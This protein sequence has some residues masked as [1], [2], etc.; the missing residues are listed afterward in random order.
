[1]ATSIRRFPFGKIDEFG[2]SKYK[3]LDE[4]KYVII[5]DLPSDHADKIE[6]EKNKYHVKLIQSIALECFLA[7]KEIFPDLMQN[8][9]ERG[10]ELL[11]KPWDSPGPGA[12]ENTRN[13]GIILLR[14]RFAYS[15]P[16]GRKIDSVASGIP[17]FYTRLCAEFLHEFGEYILKKYGCRDK[18]YELPKVSGY[19]YSSSEAFCEAFSFIVLKYSKTPNWRR[20]GLRNEPSGLKYK[21]DTLVAGLI[22]GSNG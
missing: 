12:Y 11:I 5:G 2:A 3:P 9:L 8:V 14:T 21:Y 19:S 20:E 4:N 22:E 17:D 10:D 7:I 18:D 1:M 16:R 13:G 6:Y 15:L